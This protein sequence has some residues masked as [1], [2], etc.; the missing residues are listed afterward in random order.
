MGPKEIRPLILMYVVMCLVK[1]HTLAYGC[2]P[3][4]SARDANKFARKRRK[5]IGDSIVQLR[6]SAHTPEISRRISLVYDRAARISSARTDIV[7]SHY[8]CLTD[9]V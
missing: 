4:S 9:A 3:V 7:A 8:E 1:L 5:T 2:N 6:C